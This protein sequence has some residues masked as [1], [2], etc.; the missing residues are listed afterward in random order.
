M[1]ASGGA[2]AVR[3]AA[4]TIAL[5]HQHDPAEMDEKN[6]PHRMDLNVVWLKNVILVKQC[7][8]LPK[9]HRGILLHCKRKQQARPFSERL[10]GI[11][12]YPLR[13]LYPFLNLPSK[14]NFLSAAPTTRRK[15]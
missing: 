5:E 8:L 7:S 13:S 3:Y 4:A 1:A 15:R 11:H 10:T 2:N 12:F 9:K 6:D 14:Q